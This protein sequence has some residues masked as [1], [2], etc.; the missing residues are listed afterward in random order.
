MFI[1]RINE[2]P[3]FGNMSF[4]IRKRQLK[5]VRK[6]EEKFFPIKAFY[7]TCFLVALLDIAAWIVDFGSLA[8]FLRE[9]LPWIS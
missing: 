3:R 2:I 1:V 7:L 6:K 9:F 5:E 4:V 8:K